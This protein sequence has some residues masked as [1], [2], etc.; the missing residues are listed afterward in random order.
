MSASTQTPTPMALV[1]AQMQK[2]LAVTS[3]STPALSGTYAVVGWPAN[4][5]DAQAT[6][7]AMDGTFADGTASL[8]W[9]DISNVTH[10][11]T[12]AQFK[13]LLMAIANFRNLCT[14]YGMG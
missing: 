1:M 10:A 8:N 14:L 3:T 2:G 13:T 9:P 4:G 5:L 7:I 12:V 6:A 11:F